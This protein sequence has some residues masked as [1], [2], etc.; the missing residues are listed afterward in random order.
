M[1][2]SKALYDILLQAKHEAFANIVT[3]DESMFQFS[4]GVNGVWLHEEEEPIEVEKSRMSVKK[5]MLTVMWGIKGIYLIN[6]LPEHQKFNSEYFVSNILT[7]MGSMKDSIWPRKTSRYMWLHL[8]NCRVHNSKTTDQKLPSIYMK[9]APHP[10]YSPDLAPSD[11]FLFG[12]IKGQLRGQ[13]FRSREELEEKITEILN[14]I[15]L[16]MIHSFF[17]EW[18][19]RCSWVFEHNGAYYHK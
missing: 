19:H 4:Y 8:D 12:F 6:F 3:G 9:R 15:S 17:E 1:E 16:E 13:L 14:S 2:K 11:F 10:A 18:I 5:L 7:P